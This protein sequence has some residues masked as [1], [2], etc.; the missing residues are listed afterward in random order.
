MIDPTASWVSQG[1]DLSMRTPG[2]ITTVEEH[3]DIIR[4]VC[5]E[6]KLGS[7]SMLSACETVALKVQMSVPRILELMAEWKATETISDVFSDIIIFSDL[8]F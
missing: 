8:I 2:K 5:E 3:V 4:R 7:H 6:I 1:L